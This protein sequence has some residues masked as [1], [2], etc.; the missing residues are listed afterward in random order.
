MLINIFR[1]IIYKNCL[2]HQLQMFKRSIFLRIN[3]VLKDNLK[4]I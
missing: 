4:K 1:F 3:N 2:L